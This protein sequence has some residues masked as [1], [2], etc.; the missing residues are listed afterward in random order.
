MTVQFAIEG[1]GCQS[2]VGR[3]RTALAGV[4]GVEVVDVRRGH[5]IVRREAEGNSGDGD[6]VIEALRAAGYP[7]R[8]EVTDVATDLDVGGARA[9]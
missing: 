1:M 7:A 2:C 5:A 8:R 3:V 9:V 6:A 4:D